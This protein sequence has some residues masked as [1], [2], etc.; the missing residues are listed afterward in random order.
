MQGIHWQSSST[1][2]WT[3]G[4]V[5]GKCAAGFTTHWLEDYWLYANMPVNGGGTAPA[6]KRSKGGNLDITSGNWDVW[7][8]SWKPLPWI[9]TPAPISTPVDKTPPTVS[10]TSPLNGTVVPRSTAIT[11]KA[12]ASDNIAVSK[13]E[14]YYKGGKVTGNTLICSATS[15][16][17]TCNWTTP[18]V[19]NIS[20]TITAK[21]YDASDNTSSATVILNV[22]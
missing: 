14:F 20:Y 10:I 15:A 18:S 21:A 6:L 5:T 7:F 19:R 22:R 1:T 2:N 8:D 11:L 4:S 12:T 13:V 17:Y 3:T 16:P 9:P